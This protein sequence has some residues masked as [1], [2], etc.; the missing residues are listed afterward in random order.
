M[1][2]ALLLLLFVLP[3]CISTRPQASYFMPLHEVRR[4]ADAA[5]RWGDFTIQPADS[6]YAYDDA[7]V[8]VRVV[9]LRGSFLLSVENK[10]E[11]SLQVIWDEMVYVSPTGI[12]GKVTSGETRVMNMGQAQTPTVI[13]AQA[14]AI[15]TAIPNDLFVTGPAGNRLLDFVDPCEDP[16]KYE[17]KDVRLVIPFKIQ[18]VVN[19]Y[20]FVFRLE[21]VAAPPLT[22]HDRRIFCG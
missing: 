13:P 9:P 16:A 14:K 18:D 7:L 1:K 4:P 20:T 8:S 21:D 12:A 2:R 15:L 6:G 11:H 5:Q 3:A 10:T 22:P 19:E 17:G